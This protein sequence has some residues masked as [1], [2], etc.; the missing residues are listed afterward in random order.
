MNKITQKEFKNLLQTNKTALVLS[1]FT[2]YNID[3]TYLNK[4]EKFVEKNEKNVFL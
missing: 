2:M 1:E 4:I 3:E